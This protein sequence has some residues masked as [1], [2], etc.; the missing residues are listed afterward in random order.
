MHFN[1]IIYCTTLMMFQV[2]LQ[3]IMSAVV[4]F[5]VSM[6][7]ENYAFLLSLAFNAVEKTGDTVGHQR[8][9]FFSF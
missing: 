6:E 4:W 7:I 2:Y 8:L 9:Q 1:N 3:K 5:C